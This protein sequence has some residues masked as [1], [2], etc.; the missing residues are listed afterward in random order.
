MKGG[1]PYM[2]IFHE[3]DCGCVGIP[4]GSKA[5]ILVACDRGIEDNPYYF[6]LRDMAKKTSKPVTLEQQEGFVKE[7]NSL[8]GDGY[9]MRDVSRAVMHIANR[10]VSGTK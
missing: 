8:M 6:S 3:Y 10:P 1:E 2:I 4:I 5:L 7:I 9:A